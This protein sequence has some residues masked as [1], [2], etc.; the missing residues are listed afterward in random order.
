MFYEMP[1]EWNR[2]LCEYWKKAY[3]GTWEEFHLCEAKAKILHGNCQTEIERYD[4]E[5]F[6]EVSRDEL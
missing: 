2:Q 1:C 3:G 5:E 6:E 4:T